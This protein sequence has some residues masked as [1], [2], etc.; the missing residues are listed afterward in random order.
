[1][2]SVEKIQQNNN[3]QLIDLSE[4]VKKTSADDKVKFAFLEKML[5]SQETSTLSL[6]TQMSELSGVQKNIEGS[7]GA[8]FSRIDVMEKEL[9]AVKVGLNDVKASTQS[10]SN[11]MDSNQEESRSKYKKLKEKHKKLDES[12]VELKLAHAKDISQLRQD[13]YNV[14]KVLFRLF[15]GIPQ[16][17]L[18]NT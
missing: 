18:R 3:Q 17:A 9:A 11:K 7:I 2:E 1:M 10:I 5:A 4:V 15:V 13:L 8:L 14:A 12:I 16:I 6:T